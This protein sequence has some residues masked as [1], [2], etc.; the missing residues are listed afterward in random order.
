MPLALA[1][2]IAKKCMGASTVQIRIK[3]LAER[4]SPPMLGSMAASSI[5]GLELGHQV[6]QNVNLPAACVRSPLGKDEDLNSLEGDLVIWFICRYGVSVCI[7]P[8]NTS[9]IY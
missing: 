9:V 5:L 8:S 1:S 3:E 2:L 4:D 7:R 6:H